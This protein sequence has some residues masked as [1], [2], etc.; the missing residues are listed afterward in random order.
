MTE[1]IGK[2]WQDILEESEAPF[3]KSF[4]RTGCLITMNGDKD[5]LIC[6]QN[7]PK[8]YYKSLSQ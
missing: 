3:W 2:A 8:D 5:E 4:E 1:W 6:P 7:F